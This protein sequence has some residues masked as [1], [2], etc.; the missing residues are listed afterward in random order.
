MAK[1]N[2]VDQEILALDQERFRAMVAAD[3][4]VLNRILSDDL[5]YIH[6]SSTVDTKESLTAALAAGTL[7]YESIVSGN[8]TVRLYGD[9]T[10]MITGNADVR[11]N[12]NE[13][14]L[15]FTN[16][17]IKQA[18]RWQMVSWHASRLP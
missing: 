1:A 5:S 15:R 3:I 4:G 12:G 9:T 17:Y 13:F 18:S 8:S 6:T 10:A 11:V 2:S 14:S 16:I 7:N